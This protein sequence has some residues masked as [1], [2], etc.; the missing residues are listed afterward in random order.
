MTVSSIWI[1]F[2]LGVRG[3]YEGLYS[4][5]DKHG[6]K[7]CGDSIAF[8][9]YEHTGPMLTALKK[10][11]EKSVEVTRKTRFYVMYRES[12]TKLMKGKFIVGGRKASP[13]E[14]YAGGSTE[15]D[16]DNP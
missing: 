9:K 16:E 11:L 7:E 1:S 4:W 2:D 6:A 13:W 5:L 12:D 14:G 15:A 8:L 10:D 3:D